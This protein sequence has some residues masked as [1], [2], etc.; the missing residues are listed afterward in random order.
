MRSFEALE[1]LYPTTRDLHRAALRHIPRFVAAYID[2][3]SGA[4]AAAARNRHAFDRVTLMPRYGR[5]GVVPSLETVLFGQAYAAPFGV[6]PMG[7]GAL[8]RPRLEERLARAAQAA[9]IPYVL[10]AA[11]SA[12]IETVARLAPDVFWFQLFGLPRDDHRVTLDLVRRADIAG[13]R[14]LVLTVDTPVQ[15]RRP[16]DIRNRL[17]TAGFERRPAILADI[18]CRPSWAA[19]MLRHGRPG[20]EIFRRYL[21]KG[22]SAADLTAFARAEI[23]GG[24]TWDFV[25]RIRDVWPRALVVKGVLHGRDAIEAIGAGADGIIVSNH[26]G[27]T[28]DATPPSLDCLPQIA[29]AC[30]GKAAVMLDSGLRGGLDIARALA[31][32][33]A[34]TFLG[35]PFLH[36]A[37]AIGEEGGDYLIRLLQTELRH[38]MIQLGTS[39]IE[40][41]ASIERGRAYQA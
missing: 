38:S 34:T 8:V 30:D 41:L 6:A 3:G 14:V 18:L 1:P 4:D 23:E 10:S 17:A 27:R 15:A 37:A 11:A 35:R 28:F 16:N 39:T 22:A 9:K 21:P 2:G 32:G 40:E 25:R 13:A 24:F 29:A 19:E 7:L 12:D 5:G 36:A 31:S 20:C 33:A 26:G